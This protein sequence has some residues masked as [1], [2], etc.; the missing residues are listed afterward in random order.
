MLPELSGRGLFVFSDPGGAKPV[1]AIV[2]HLN[3]KG[4]IF[5][6]VIISDRQYDFFSDFDVSVI[7]YQPGDE[8]K[9]TSTFTPDFLVTGT[10]YTSEIE[11]LFIE[12]AQARKVFSFTFV[13]HYSNLLERFELNNQYFFPSCIGL[14]DET[15]FS[16]ALDSGLPAERLSIIP[17]PYHD[18]LLGWKPSVER[19]AFLRSHNLDVNKKLILYAPDPLTN[20]GG[21]DRYGCDEIS[22]LDTLLECASNS[23]INFQVVVRPH[24]N[25]NINLFEPFL[26]DARV[27][28]L[29]FAHFNT[30]LT[31]SDIVIS[32]FSNI[33]IESQLLSVKNCR[34][35]ID[36]KGEDYL[37]DSGY[38]GIPKVGSPR[39]L[40]NLL[41]TI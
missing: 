31:Y 10:S 36:F 41:N 7:Q 4:L 16:K 26:R 8:L 22:S 33:L 32:F 24:P 38:A 30:L 19:E 27:T 18:Y 1:L 5:E 28:I 29:P 23:N 34:M 11:L 14:V 9:Y 40:V 25:Q 35:L 20:V 13:D 17:N 39:Q 6:Q 21:V 2:H 15:A 12:Q 37:N 3:Q